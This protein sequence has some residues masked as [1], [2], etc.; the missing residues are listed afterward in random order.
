MER[1]LKLRV[2]LALSASL[3]NWQSAMSQETPL[4]P[5]RTTPLTAPGA[6]NP[7]A[8]PES[9]TAPGD[10]AVA[11]PMVELPVTPEQAEADKKLTGQAS[12]SEFSLL[13]SAIVLKASPM[14]RYMGPKLKIVSV[15]IRNNGSYP[16]VVLGD[17][18]H[19]KGATEVAPL[20]LSTVLKLDDHLLTKTQIGTIAGVTAATLGLAGPIF[21][22]I[23]TEED[24]RKRS[25]GTA[26]G[27][28]AGRHEVEANRLN[29]RVILPQDET[30][31]WIAFYDKDAAASTSLNI[32]VLYPYNKTLGTVTVPLSH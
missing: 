30:T 26:V 3:L 10:A 11:A 24:C 25:L 13:G 8:T 18:A 16:V 15:T 17:S 5:L 32:P 19:G 7:T 27:R 31:G 2:V 6:A 4:L 21:Y 28:D 22:E 20:P 29:R 1:K 14:T 12:A 9:S 23:M